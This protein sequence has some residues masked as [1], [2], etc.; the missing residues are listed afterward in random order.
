MRHALAL[1]TALALGALI[2]PAHAE[3]T[4]LDVRPVSL[5]Y[6]IYLTAAPDDGIDR[7]ERDI[8]LAPTPDAKAPRGHRIE[9]I[10]PDGRYAHAGL[11]VGDVILA[12]NGEPFTAKAAFQ[13]IHTPQLDRVV[14]NAER[15]GHA[16]DI[17][18]IIHRPPPPT[19]WI[20]QTAPHTYTVT[21]ADFEALLADPSALAR[22]AR[23]IPAREGDTVTGMRL[24]AIRPTSIYAALGFLNGDIIHTVNGHPLSSPTQALD[25]YAAIRRAPEITLTLT[26]AKAPLTLRYTIERAPAESP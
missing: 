9:H 7:I 8:R 12:I 20:R 25:A 21:A 26:R 13:T 6:A 4:E 1:A 11:A 24:F 17:T 16:F 14:L 23:V 2:P 10:A 3:L 18:Y 15:G 22:G 5:T 19:D